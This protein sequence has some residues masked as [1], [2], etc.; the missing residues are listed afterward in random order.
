[1]EPRREDKAQKLAKELELKAI[2]AHLNKINGITGKTANR[3]QLIE[4]FTTLFM[5]NNSQKII[6]TAG[7]N[8]LIFILNHSKFIILLSQT[9]ETAAN[10]GKLSPESPPYWLPRE[11]W[12]GEVKDSTHYKE[13]DAKFRKPFDTRYNHIEQ[14]K[15]LGE[16]LSVSVTEYFPTSLHDKVRLP[17]NEK[18]AKTMVQL[19]DAQRINLACDVYQQI[20]NVYSYL[21]D[22][23]Y[24]WLDL[25]PGNIMIRDDGSIGIPDKKAFMAHEDVLIRSK[26]SYSINLVNDQDFN[27][28]KNKLQ[29][30]QKMSK[31]FHLKKPQNTEEPLVFCVKKENGEI[32]EGSIDKDKLKDNFANETEYLQFRENLA[33]GKIS[34]SEALRILDLAHENYATKPNM[35]TPDFEYLPITQAFCSDAFLDVGKTRLSPSS[36][37]AREEFINELQMEYSFQLGATLYIML[38]GD[39]Q[40]FL[41]LKTNKQLDFSDTIFKTPEGTKL[42]ALIENLTFAVPEK[43]MHYKEALNIVNQIRPPIERNFEAIFT[44]PEPKKNLSLSG[45]GKRASKMLSRS[46]NS[47]NISRKETEEVIPITE[48]SAKTESMEK[49][50]PNESKANKSPSLKDIGR[51]LSQTRLSQ[52]A[53][54]PKISR[55]EPGKETAKDEELMK[56]DKITSRRIAFK[57]RFS[58]KNIPSSTSS[59]SSTSSL[60]TTSSTPSLS[61]SSNKE[62]EQTRREAAKQIKQINEIEEAAKNKNKNKNKK[63]PTK[64][65]ST[66]TPNP[67]SRSPK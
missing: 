47:P 16:F 11:F 9:R 56:P 65:L 34:P 66:S 63:S 52:S 7:N 42:Q 54:S 17:K 31:Q 39:E 24:L 62:Q 45:F 55:E 13:Q 3:P 59:T 19:S 10:V 64:A 30:D 57:K 33:S 60:S 28:I 25:K 12:T 26:P 14:G 41:S 48:V 27:E 40:K 46:T 2:M 37:Q 51:R 23:N 50:L 21:G 8:N 67:F 61:S 36:K 15:P 53:I 5:E 4:D 32:M 43:R 35:H 49:S 6:A 1:M 29:T 44:E 18:E 22:H 38:T 58:T 20:A